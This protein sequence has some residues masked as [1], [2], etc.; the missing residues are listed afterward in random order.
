MQ[1][2][3]N[4]A[5]RSPPF[6]RKATSYHGWLSHWCRFMIKQT[7]NNER[8]RWRSMF[9]ACRAAI[10][11]PAGSTVA[12][13]LLPL[14]ILDM[15]CFGDDKD[16]YMTMQEVKDVLSYRPT[17][18]SNKSSS[19]LSRLMSANDLHKA[20]VTIFS[21][22][23]TLKN[24][25]ENETEERHK[26][27]RGGSGNEHMSLNSRKK[28]D[29]S[30]S[31]NEV[32]CFSWPPDESIARINDLFGA[33]PLSMFASAAAGV[34]MN[35]RAL[36]YL[37]MDSRQQIVEQIYDE[38]TLD[39]YT[40]E[41]SQDMQP[42]YSA[43]KALTPLRNIDLRLM[44]Q[45]LGELNESDAMIA[46]GR[47][48][49]R[50][51]LSH[52]IIDLIHER[53]AVGD[54][55]GALQ[56]YE[57]A[58]QLRPQTY[59]QS[60][61]SKIAE[62]NKISNEQL[63]LEK[64]MCKCLLE[65]GQLESVINQ[66]SGILSNSEYCV[67]DRSNSDKYFASDERA[68]MEL[69][70]S[71]TEAAWRLGRW[72]LLEKLV[73]K[74]SPVFLNSTTMY[75]AES[76]YHIHIGQAFLGLH[77]RYANVV[78]DAIRCARLAVM[79]SLSSVARESYPRFYPYLLRLH[80]IREIENASETLCLNL[81]NQ[82]ET[83]KRQDT[84]SLLETFAAYVTSNSPNAWHWE[85]RMRLA[86]P[87]L[88]GSS[89]LGNVRLALSRIAEEPS[90]EGQLWL[91]MGRSARKAGLLDIAHTAFAHAEISF[92]SCKAK[93]SIIESDYD[94]YFLTSF[95]N[96]IQLQL[97]KL[98]HITG[99]TSVALQMMNMEEI[100][101]NELVKKKDIDIDA[102]IL[103]WLS[104]QHYFN[105]TKFTIENQSSEQLKGHK[106]VFGRRLLQATEWIVEGGLCGPEITNRYKLV[107]R[108][109]PDLER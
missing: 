12:E 108:V 47:E 32:I 26:S 6:F 15:I 23:D 87:E 64:G 44:Q 34:G 55:N 79:T 58:L 77:R 78:S 41:T 27:M 72:S 1:R 97:A 91:S 22:L 93:S 69:I 71:A 65:L 46:V 50:L 16:E 82:V 98:N 49:E 83:T 14:L 38:V 42:L 10:R 18:T 75:D 88:A 43:G 45:L 99:E 103:L 68:Q 92:A 52:N 102:S 20:V 28:N 37:E 21:T 40:S 48:L 105:T 35:A 81:S 9:H 67:K 29:V 2:N 76:L 24:W 94:E 62:N 61:N 84:E 51:G 80:C 39:N 56:G 70:P 59:G 19:P 95:Q 3:E 5:F 57:Q 63:I 100:N 4:V 33:L 96:E 31:E 101:M 73:N 53:E 86:A 90:L 13:F 17:D 109:C 7:C 74:A 11:S 8:S 66:V 85:G 30:S 60:Q 89:V 54:W 104:R 36:Q 106:K 107:Q 25:A